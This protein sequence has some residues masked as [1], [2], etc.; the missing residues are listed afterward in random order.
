MKLTALALALALLAGCAGLPVPR[1]M[2][3]MALLRTIGAD[4]HEEGVALTAATGPR[5]KGRQGVEDALVVTRAGSTP[6]A[7][8]LA[9]EQESGASLFFGYADRVLA[10]EGL[11]K[12]GGLLPLLDW[13]AR[14]EELGLGA[15]LWAVEGAARAGLEGQA[16]G[17][18][19]RLAALITDG[20]LGTAPLT[21]TAGEVYAHLLDRGCAWVPAL[22][23][24]E[25]GLLPDGYTILYKDGTPAGRL[26][27]EGARGLEL[28]M[29]S[30]RVHLLTAGG[31]TARVYR[32]QTSCR[33]EGDGVLFV[34]CRVWA[35]LGEGTGPVDREE[36]AR[37]MARQE[38]AAVLA[39][40]E[41]LRGWG[42]DCLGLGA[43]A[44]LTSPALW[45][46]LE[47]D[48]PAEFSR[49]IPRVTVDV[50][51]IR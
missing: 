6:G 28:L 8:A 14:E 9:M 33:F 30:P 17:A 1:E 45:Q 16:D 51:L 22:K 49:Q 26:T 32:G 21:R 10:G 5:P 42:T 31:R 2:G 18:E 12:A 40:L 41:G 3:E 36:L 34:K 24:G 20:R 37:E 4:A 29:G 7:A 25:E 39:A 23:A 35:R 15:N 27:G 38:E 19:T 48:W 50:E 44:G 43:R 47:G 11:L 13:L 46:K